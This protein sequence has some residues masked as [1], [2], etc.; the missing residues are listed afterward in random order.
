MEPEFL[1]TS[2]ALATFLGDLGD[3][4]GQ[5]PRFYV[6]LEGNNLSRRGTL[7]LVTIL[8][9]P[10]RTLYLVDV[11]TIGQEAFTIA[12]AN[13]RTLQNSLESKDIVKVFFDMRNDSDALFCLYGIRV[14]G[15]EDLQLMELASRLFAKRNVNGLVMCIERDGTIDFQ[16]RRRWQAVK[17]QGKRLFDPQ[18]GGS[19]AVFDQRPL[20]QDVKG[21]T[22][23][24]T[25]LSCR[26]SEMS[27]AGSYVTRGGGRSRRRPV[28]HSN[29]AGGSDL[30]SACT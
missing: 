6:D 28:R 14:A 8:L 24:R 4:D 5:P 15:I 21:T 16:E 2:T 26:I 20:S 27:T 13:G 23:H 3:C 10:E 25:S 11:T 7:S 12:G 9:E 30:G 22:A 19:Y 18:Q 29:T 17:D 1:D